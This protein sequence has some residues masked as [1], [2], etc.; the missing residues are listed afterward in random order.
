MKY[1]LWPSIVII[2]ALTLSLLFAAFS[3]TPGFDTMNACYSALMLSSSKPPVIQGPDGPMLCTSYDTPSGSV[4]EC[5]Y[6]KRS[7]C[8]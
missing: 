7:V 6:L 5:R 2:F 8:R 4:L 1:W 3:R